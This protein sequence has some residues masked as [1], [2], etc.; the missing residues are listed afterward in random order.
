MLNW[1]Q[2]WRIVLLM[3]LSVVW[4][5]SGNLRTN[6]TPLQRLEQLNRTQTISQMATPTCEEVL[7]KCSDAVTK[8]KAVIKEQGDVI[9]KQ[10]EIIEHAE[11]EIDR[12]HSETNKAIVGGTSTS[13]FLLLLLLL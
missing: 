4:S 7:E 11:K 6:Q 9:K 12:A 1:R 3:I 2:T 10:G 8:Q 5:C 13:I